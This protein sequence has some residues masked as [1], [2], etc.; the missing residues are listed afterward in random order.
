V[1]HSTRRANIEVTTVVSVE[2]L[3]GVRDGKRHGAL[4]VA[5]S[6]ENGLSLAAVDRVA[7]A[8]APGDRSFRYRLV[9]K[10]TLERRKRNGERLS[11]AEGDRLARMVKVY[12]MAM[13]VY[14]DPAKAVAFLSGPHQ[15]LEGRSAL[16]VAL[17]SGPGADEVVNILG[18][19]YYGTGV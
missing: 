7:A 4:A 19:A 1:A 10:P 14:K 18:R 5:R 13:W 11:V 3:L 17:A 6:V 16:D 15:M 12:E 2:D 8:L 9:P